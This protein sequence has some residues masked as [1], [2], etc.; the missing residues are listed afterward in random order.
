MA[1]LEIEIL[2]INDNQPQFEV[3]SYNISIVENLPNGFSVLQVIATDMDQVCKIYFLNPCLLLI[4]IF[5]KNL[6]TFLH[7]YLF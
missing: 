3:G 5:R 2:D 4:F 7:T 1:R 6:Y